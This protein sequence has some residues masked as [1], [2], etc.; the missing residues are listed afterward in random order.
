M[1]YLKS[2]KNKI[3]KIYYASQIKNR[4][5]WGNKMLVISLGTSDYKTA[6]KRHQEI[7]DKERALKQG[8]KFD[9]SWKSNTKRAKLV[10][11]NLGQLIDD[12]LAIKKVNVR[13]SS[14][15]RYVVSMK[16]FVNAVGKTTPL[17]TIN[18]STIE[19]FK[20][21]YVD[22]HKVGGININL[23]GI[24]CF[25]KWAF[26]EGH[27]KSMPKINML[28]ETK[29]KPKIIN[30][31]TWN[32]MMALDIDDYWKDVW[33]LYRGIG[34]RLSESINGVINGDF[35]VVDAKYSKSGIEREILINAEQKRTIK[36][37]QLRR[38]SHL[39]KG[40][41]IDTFKNK[42]TKTFRDAMRELDLDLTFHCLRHTFAVRTYLQTRD[43]FAVSRMLGHTSLKTT[44]VYAQFNFNRLEQEFPSLVNLNAIRGQKETPMGETPLRL[45][46]ISREYN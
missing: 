43:I 27:I 19:Y 29:S 41:I 23:R 6:I 10:T 33:T 11:R 7:E 8:M 45:V 12:W 3:G 22:V 26:E 34:I 9:W 21:F 2:V 13:T 14:Y 16:A 32:R 37:I 39:A 30:D 1:A 44:E 17:S 18:T 31:A 36:E 38:D 24:K 46:G 4:E 20:K 25:L 35:L 42:F 28:K 40:S 15:K 5:E